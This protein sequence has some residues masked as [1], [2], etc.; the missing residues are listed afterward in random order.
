MDG[1]LRGRT[2]MSA[3]FAAGDHLVVFR[4]DRLGLNHSETVSLAAGDFRRREWRPAK[5]TVT[6][7]AVPYAEVFLGPKRLGLTPMEPVSLYEGSYQ[8]RF[9]NKETGRTET[10]P[11]EVLPGQDSLV[12]VDL[13]AP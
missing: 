9:V 12:K 11:V 4:E 3:P 5:G 10:M 2:P 8:F 6:I 7:R 1:V 13:R